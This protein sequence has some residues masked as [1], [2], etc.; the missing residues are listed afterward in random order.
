MHIT[1]DVLEFIEELVD[2]VRNNCLS[3]YFYTQ[4]QAQVQF[5]K[6]MAHAAKAIIIS[7]PCCI[8]QLSI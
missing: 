5:E 3:R 6:S 1:S 2:A 7:L 8:L 4:N